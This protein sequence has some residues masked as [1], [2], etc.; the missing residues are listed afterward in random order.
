MG[1]ATAPLP[2]LSRN[3]DTAAQ[4][5]SVD[6]CGSMWINVDEMGSM[7]IN[8]DEMGSKWMKNQTLIFNF[9]YF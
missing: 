3:K 5:R 7:W 4:N 2:L 9:R 6:Q 8:V 1:S